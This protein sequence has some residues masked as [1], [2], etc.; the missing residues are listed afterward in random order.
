MKKQLILLFVL[1]FGLFAYAQKNEMKAVEKAIKGNNFAEAKAAVNSAEGLISAMDEKTKAKFY[2]LKA[3]ALYANGN[4]SDEDLNKAVETILEAESMN[5]SKYKDDISEL[6]TSML[7]SFLTKANSK[8][9]SKSY[10]ASSNDFSRAY[11]MSPSDTLYLYYAASTAVNAQDYDTSLEYY[12]KLRDIGFTGIG[13]QYVATNKDTGEEENFGNS[14]MR[15]LSVK[16]GTHT[17]P[18]DIKSKSK[19]AEI[20]KNIALIYVNQGDNEKAVEAMKTAREEN[21]D[22]LGLLLTEANVQL[23]MGNMDKFKVLMEKATKMDPDNAELQYNLGVIAADSGDKENAKM[24]YEKAVQLD[25]EYGDAYTNLA[26]LIL[27]REQAIVEEMNS[28]GTSAADDKKY[29]E[30]QEER[31]ELFKSAIPY[32][33][34]SL[35]LS[36]KNIDIMRTLRNIYSSVGDTEKYKEYKAKVEAIEAGN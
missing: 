10:A 9:Q 1:S 8:L 7:N 30:L 34:K 21:P 14:T 35:S 5:N 13:Y 25:P 27:D 24:Y 19:S 6:K 3:Q 33:E 31:K 26:V 16:S 11:K 29:D 17:T 32:L 2:L 15:D 20:I 28:L 23:K 12:E 22:D 18:R 36:P 4:G